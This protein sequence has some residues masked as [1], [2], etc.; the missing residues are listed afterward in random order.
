MRKNPP[1]RVSLPFVITATAFLLLFLTTAAK[2]VVAEVAD[3]SDAQ[4]AELNAVAIPPPA[5]DV[6]WTQVQSCIELTLTDGKL[7]QILTY[8]VPGQLCVY[9]DAPLSITRYIGAGYT[10]IKDI[11]AADKPAAFLTLPSKIVTGIED[12][13]ITF[14]AKNQ[15]SLSFS[16]SYFA[17][18]WGQFLGTVDAFYF[19]QHSK[20]LKPTQEGMAV[21]S[22]AARSRSQLHIHMACVLPAV[23]TA[24]AKAEIGA[25]WSSKPITLPPNSHPYYAINVSNLVSNNPFLEM[26][27]EPHFKSSQPG[28]QTL[29]VT[30]APSGY[31]VLLDYVTTTD[32]ALGEELLD[33]KCDQ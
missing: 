24:L 18:A 17:D 11:N 22:I 21:N 30:G 5:P 19:K 23:E 10:V 29:V 3:S 13:Q 25:H 6:L 33:Q 28:D 8:S 2:D 1:Y 14:F 20:H 27:S 7:N 9:V 4:S 32:K 26:Q 15:S 31:Y 16:D 12:P